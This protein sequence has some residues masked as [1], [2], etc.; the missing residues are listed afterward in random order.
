M[1][2]VH[3]EAGFL[4]MIGLEDLLQCHDTSDGEGNFTDNQGLECDGSEGLQTNRSSNT[5]GGQ[6]GSNDVAAAILFVTTSSRFGQIEADG[7]GL[8]ELDNL[9]NKCLIRFTET[10]H[11]SSIGQSEDGALRVLVSGHVLLLDKS[12]SIHQL[13]GILSNNVCSS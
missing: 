7:V 5:H 2:S 3:L 13:D 8:E 9:L 12:Y 11:R 6:E 10:F 4:V 1:A